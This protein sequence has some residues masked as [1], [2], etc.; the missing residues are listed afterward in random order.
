MKKHFL[1]TA[2]GSY[3][4]VFVTVMLTTYL[5]MGKDVFDLDAESIKM[6]ISA[7]FTSSIP[8][9]INALNPNDPRYGKSKETKIVEK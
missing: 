6:L 4:K 9:L 2:F 8:I 3:L 7:A 5:A 1:N